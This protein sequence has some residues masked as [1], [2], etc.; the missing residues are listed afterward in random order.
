VP[1]ISP[2]NRIEFRRLLTASSIRRPPSA[3]VRTDRAHYAEKRN[4]GP[5]AA[6]FLT[7]N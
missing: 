7:S 2:V 1:T 3:P 4:G 6:A 5:K